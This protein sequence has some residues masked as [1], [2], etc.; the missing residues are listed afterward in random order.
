MTRPSARR[1]D[2]TTDSRIHRTDRTAT[3]Q[4]DIGSCGLSQVLD[5]SVGGDQV[6][7]AVAVEPV[8][9]ELDRKRR[10]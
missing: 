8:E 1:P 4:A 5:G 3:D 9:N 2:A 10:E 6:D 7:D